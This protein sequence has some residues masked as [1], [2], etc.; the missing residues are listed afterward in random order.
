[1]LDAW[2]AAKG[3]N[4]A[5]EKDAH[6]ILSNLGFNIKSLTFKKSGQYSW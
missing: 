4:Q 6:Q 3:R 2:F 5:T 1:M